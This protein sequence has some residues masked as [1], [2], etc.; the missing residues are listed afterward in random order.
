[1][2]AY[3]ARTKEFCDEVKLALQGDLLLSVQRELRSPPLV[4]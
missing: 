2:S 1:L 4:D 3:L